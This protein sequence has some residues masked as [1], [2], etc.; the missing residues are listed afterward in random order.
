M[1]A[2]LDD[3]T[4]IRDLSSADFDLF[5]TVV[6]SLVTRTFIQRGVEKEAELY[7]FTLR[8][9]RL[10]DSWFSC[11]DAELKTDEALG[12]IAFRGPPGMRFHFSR[13]EICAVLSLRLLY[14][15]KKVEVSLTRF[16]VASIAEFK[17]KYN[18][19]TGGELKKTALEAIL[20]RLSGCRL[21]GIQGQEASDDNTLLEL[22]PSIAMSIDR[23][24]L[25]QGIAY[26][27]A[28]LDAKLEA[29]NKDKP[30]AEDAENAE[31]EA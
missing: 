3:L 15:D 4:G 21:I 23:E 17:E 29:K 1:S 14:E 2:N 31:E 9:I 11:M 28:K 6:R 8:N 13:E 10:F 16:P 20:S 5:K 22:Y 19:V 12:V 25:D 27:D 24:A 7:D 18:A 26:L 30:R